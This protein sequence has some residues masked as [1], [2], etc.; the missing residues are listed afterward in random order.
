M[1]EIG[2]TEE[3]N[4][5]PS[6]GL[7]LTKQSSD[8]AGRNGSLSFRG[9]SGGETKGPGERLVALPGPLLLFPHVFV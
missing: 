9:R 1:G 5:D 4:P 8:A 2:R 7:L 6:R 3:A